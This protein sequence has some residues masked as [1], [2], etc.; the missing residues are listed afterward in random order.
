MVIHRKLI[1]G[2][3]L[4]VIVVAVLLGSTGHAAGQGNLAERDK[5]VTRLK[6]NATQ[7]LAQVDKNDEWYSES[8]FEDDVRRVASVLVMTGRFDEAWS[9][10]ES[11]RQLTVEDYLLVAQWAS[12]ADQVDYALQLA[13]QLSEPDKA[14]ALQLIVV[15]QA[16]RGDIQD[17]LQLLPQ[18]SNAD[19]KAK[20]FAIHAICVQYAREKKYDEAEKLLPT[21]GQA[22]VRE[23][24]ESC[25]KVL[26]KRRTP[27]E[28]G[29]SKYKTKAAISY[30]AGII[31]WV[32]EAEVALAKGNKRLA[33]RHLLKAS[34]V[35]RS[36]DPKQTHHVALQIGKVADQAG[37]TDFARQAFHHAIEVELSSNGDWYHFQDSQ[38]ES[39]YISNMRRD[40]YYKIILFNL[41]AKSHRALPVGERNKR[42]T[43]RFFLI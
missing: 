19:P 14:I 5:W 39:R 15:A 32:A 18:I 9:W 4:V 13:D 10:I 28:P 8:S 7:A 12:R 41:I 36:T 1:S 17:A 30:D 27:E 20:D 33:E 43:A 22:D 37:M 42:T 6:E 11:H 40:Q 35:L 21:I 26:R 25:L 16:K 2:V 34:E 3:T 24:T 38:G 31:R 29:Y 23:S